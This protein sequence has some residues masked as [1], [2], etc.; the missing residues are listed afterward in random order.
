MATVTATW[1][2]ATD[3][4]QGKQAGGETGAEG[5]ST[6]LLLCQTLDGVLCFALAWLSWRVSFALALVLALLIAY[7][8][9]RQLKQRCGKGSTRL[10]LLLGRPL[11]ARPRRSGAR[12]PL[13]S[14][15]PPCDL[16]VRSTRT[17]DG[18]QA[19]AFGDAWPVSARWPEQDV[20]LCI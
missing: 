4:M 7:I 18:R 10:I 2:A 8:L 19:M 16:T 17:N 14:G 1:I 20:C 15:G 12:S 3:K 9:Q 6:L 13:V 5:A 11:R